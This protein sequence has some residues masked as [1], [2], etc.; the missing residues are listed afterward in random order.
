M[1]SAVLQVDFS[2]NASVVN[3]NEIQ[4]AHH[5]VTIGH[6]WVNQN[7][8]ESFVIVSDNLDHTK[9]AVYTFMSELFDTINKKYSYIN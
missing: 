9:E 6:V 2:E 8:K 4:L 7:V 5:Q 3:Q 1:S